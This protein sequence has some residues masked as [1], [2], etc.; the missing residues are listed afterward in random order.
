MIRMENNRIDKLL[1]PR[2]CL[3][4]NTIVK[5]M[6]GLNDIQQ[7][8][9]KFEKK[10][11]TFVGGKHALAV[12][13]GTDGLQLALLALGIGKGDEV[14]VPDLT[15]VSTALVVN[16]VGATPIPVDVKR[17]DLTID[18]TLI[19]KAINST[20]KAII[21]VHMFGHPCN[22]IALRSIA[23]RHGLFLI[24]DACQAFGSEYKGKMVGTE[25]DFGV[26]SFSYYKPLSSLG[27]NGGMLIFREKKFA[28][29][30]T[31]YLELWD[32]DPRHLNARF[33]FNRISIS[34][35]ITTQVKFAAVSH[36]CGSRLNIKAF[37]QKRL[38]NLKG[39]KVFRDKAGTK[40]IMENYL[41]LAENRDALYEYLRRRD[42]SCDLPYIPIHET[43]IFDGK[44][45]NSDV[46]PETKRYYSKGLHLPLY[47]LMTEKDADSVV[48][49]VRA[50]YLKKQHE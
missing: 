48:S 28:A 34:D 25:G 10:F 33:K 17:D 44:N 7:F 22:V 36:I 13:S 23:K 39:I 15:Y 12:N 30:I 1:M 43:S 20:T 14:I 8:R 40:S 49:C 46:F 29:T 5:Q 24:E 18:E 50:F 11:C 35:L 16:Y 19:E 32:A 41:I 4:L 9:E 38:A 42:I 31:K 47:S 6:D 2:Y 3:A 21:A 27:G 37:Y 45:S 26:F